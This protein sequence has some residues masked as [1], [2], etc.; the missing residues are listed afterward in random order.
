MIYERSERNYYWWAIVGLIAGLITYR[1]FFYK[2]R[3]FEA[4]IGIDFGSTFSGYSIIFDSPKDLE[5]TDNNDIVSTDLLMFKPTEIGLM[6][7]KKAKNFVEH[8]DLRP[9][10]LYFS[11]FKRNLN[12]ENKCNN[13]VDASSPLNEKIDLIK[14]ITEYLI[15]IKKKIFKNKEIAKIRD[16]IKYIITVPALWDLDGKKVM[17]EAAINADMFNCEIILEPEAAS[18]AIFQAVNI[19]KNLFVKGKT[20]LIVDVGGYTSDFSANKILSNNELEQLIVPLSLINGSTKINQKLLNI[21]KEVIGE[22]KLNEVKEKKYENYFKFLEEIEDKKKEINEMASE[23]IEINIKNLDIK[24]SGYFKKQCKGNYQGREIIYDD[25]YIEI[26]KDIAIKIIKD[27]SDD[28]IKD[29]NF[30]FTRMTSTP[31][32]LIFTGGFSSNKIFRERINNYFDGASSDVVFLNEP[33]ETVMRGA[34]LFG[35]RPTQIKKRIIPISIAIESYSKKSFEEK[36]SIESKGEN[37][38]NKRI[39][40]ITFF[41]KGKSAYTDQIIKY[42]IYPTNSNEIKIYYSNQENV[43]N[44]NKREL[45]SIN[46]SKNFI[47][48]CNRTIIVSMK[49]SNYINVTVTDESSD[50]SVHETSKLISYPTN[51]KYFQ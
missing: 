22:S 13:K 45:G 8:Y 15:L 24:C 40:Y 4:F 16:K 47:P 44:S 6:I 21:I 18:L 39:D 20:F 33:Q 32:A 2:T 35:L 30:V 14:V 51:M 46:I 1:L 48:L 7:G 9:H 49:F 25:N 28:I 19:N 41:K 38:Y 29:I 36:C 42:V 3:E 5:T 11:L 37:I 31:N 10:K 27:L 34:A 12:P 50:H 17:E 43:D 26:P 23:N